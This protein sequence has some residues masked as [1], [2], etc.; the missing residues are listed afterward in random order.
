MTKLCEAAT[1]RFCLCR[2]YPSPAIWAHAL[3]VLALRSLDLRSFNTPLLPWLIRP[4]SLTS[5]SSLG[6]TLLPIPVPIA[7]RPTRGVWIR[8]L[9]CYLRLYLRVGYRLFPL[10]QCVGLFRCRFVAVTPV[11][12][13]QAIPSTMLHYFCLLTGIA[14]CTSLGVCGR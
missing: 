10:H 14:L 3:L 7:P 9:P 1:P 5:H 11:M 2:H 8:K 12:V 13:T 6:L 4:T